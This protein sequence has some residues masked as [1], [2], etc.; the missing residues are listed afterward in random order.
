MICLTLTWSSSYATFSSSKFI[1]ILRKKI[2]NHKSYNSNHQLLSS[3][4][5]LNFTLAVLP[6]NKCY[7]LCHHL[8]IAPSV[9]ALTVALIGK[10]IPA[11]ILT[12]RYILWA[13][14]SVVKVSGENAE[15]AARTNSKSETPDHT[16]YAKI[17]C[18]TSIKRNYHC[19]PA[20]RL[21]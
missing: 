11:T 6:G 13:K 10:D 2:R 3:S 16:W 8:R 7:C 4:K 19:G 18:D 5:P 14:R 15:L 21:S 17:T 20:T 1:Q 9:S 12:R